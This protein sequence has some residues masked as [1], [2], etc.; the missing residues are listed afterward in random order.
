ME[1]ENDE[2]VQGMVSAKSFA[3]EMPKVTRL[4]KLKRTREMDLRKYE[5]MIVE[6]AKVGNEAGQLPW[7]NEEKDNGGRAKKSKLTKFT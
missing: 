2:T 3:P 7:S 1:K 6:E 4:S 5:N